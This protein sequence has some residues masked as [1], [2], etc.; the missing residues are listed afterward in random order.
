V[1]LKLQVGRW[2]C[3]NS[4]CKRKIFC[5]RL[6]GITG[7]HAQETDR[8]TEILQSVGYAMGGRAG[9]R[10]GVRLGLPISD[11]TLLRRV[12]KAARSRPESRAIPV[13]GV[14]EWAW[15]KGY[16]GYGTMLVDWNREW[17][18]TCCRID[19]P[20]PSRNGC[21]RIPK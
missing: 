13:V 8:F 17:W 3:R 2:R 11:D 21:E 19:P 14:D 10:L 15:R 18:R 9:E 4:L 1:R 12:K 5:Q 7:K 16:S 6:A 20:L